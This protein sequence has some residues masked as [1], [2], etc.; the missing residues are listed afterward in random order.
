MESFASAPVTVP[1]AMASLS[2]DLPVMNW[3]SCPASPSTPPAASPAGCLMGACTA[4]A[5]GAGGSIRARSSSA[6]GSTSC[7]ADGGGSFAPLLLPHAASPALPD[8]A[9]NGLPLA[10][11]PAE[12][13]VEEEVFQSGGFAMEVEKLLRS[14]GPGVPPSLS[15]GWL[16]ALTAL[17]GRFLPFVTLWEAGS[18]SWKLDVAPPAYAGSR[19][20]LA[21]SQSPKG[22]DARSTPHIEMFG[23][24]YDAE[25]N[26]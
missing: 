24:P 22:I 8:A 25:M 20:G 9:A 6:G 26:C 10:W 16:A 23:L 4:A 18:R 21:V 7:S 17:L 13:N 19:S 5:G 14:C 15:V 11:L 3:D 1:S 12:G 2:L